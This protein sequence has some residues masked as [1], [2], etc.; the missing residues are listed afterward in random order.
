[1]AAAWKVGCGGIAGELRVLVCL[2]PAL[3]IGG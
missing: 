1:M 2:G 3:V